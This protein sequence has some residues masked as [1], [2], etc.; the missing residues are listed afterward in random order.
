M[1]NPPNPGVSRVFRPGAG[2]LAAWEQ[3][4]ARRGHTV[5][6]LIRHVLTRAVENDSVKK[7]A[8]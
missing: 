8:A 7:D 1:Q 3:V 6:S 5:E 4:A 2:E